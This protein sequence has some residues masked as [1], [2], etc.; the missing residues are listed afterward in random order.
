LGP[1][2]GFEDRSSASVKV[3]VG[4]PDPASQVADPAEA[5]RRYDEAV[6]I[7]RRRSRRADEF[8]LVAAENAVYGFRRNAYGSNP[9]SS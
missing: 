1:R 6:G 9:R 5:D 8:P 4:W 2:F 7:L 3:R